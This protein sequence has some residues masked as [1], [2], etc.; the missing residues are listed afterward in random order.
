MSALAF[1]PNGMPNSMG[2]V[3]NL[4]RSIFELSGQT[5]ASR[6]GTVERRDLDVAR[7]EFSSKGGHEG[8]EVA[9]WLREVC[10]VPIVFVTGYT[11]RD[12]IERIHEVVPD[13]PVLPKLNYRNRLADAVA[14]MCE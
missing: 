8:I 11:D 7:M 1:V 12:T 3:L 10:D 6:S 13:A 5:I 9:R 14:E 4:E 2:F